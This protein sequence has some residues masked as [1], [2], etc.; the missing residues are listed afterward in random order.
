MQTNSI[1]LSKGKAS[2]SLSVEQKLELYQIIAYAEDGDTKSAI[3]R[4]RDMIAAT[5]TEAAA[6]TAEQIEFLRKFSVVEIVE[7]AMRADQDQP[8]AA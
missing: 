8:I 5:K 4:A 2:A 7:K 3:A 6:F 1:P